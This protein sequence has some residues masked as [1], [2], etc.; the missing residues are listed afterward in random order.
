MTSA[1]RE[2][3][4]RRAAAGEEAARLALADALD[5]E[6]RHDDAIN[7]LAAAARA[8]S[9]AAMGRVG[10]RILI[11]DRAP[12]LPQQ[13]VGLVRDAA[14]AGD[15]EALTLLATLTAAGAHVQQSWSG[16][17]DLIQR[18]AERGSASARGQL[19]V[20]ASDRSLAAEAKASA[21]AAPP[22]VWGRLRA[23]VD[24][25]GFSR[26]SPGITLCE[27]PL[28]RSFP[29]FAAPEVCDWLVARAATRLKRAEVYVGDPTKVKVGE[30]RT[31]SIGAFWLTEIDLVQLALQARMAS[32]TGLSYRHMESPSVLHYAVGQQFHDHYD[33]IDPQTPDYQ[34]LIARHG[35]RVV[36]FLV[37]LNDG[38]EGGETAFPRLDIAHTG[39]RG[40]GLY[41]A[42]A[43]PSGGPDVRALHAG[44]PPTR[45]EKWIVSQ[46]IRSR[47]FI[48]GAA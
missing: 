20:L 34:A 39:A 35:E 1:T 14:S 33:F 32:A 11:G 37:Y 15:P 44:R 23:A 2:D 7:M 41:F 10:A 47:P 28:I 43:L 45:G 48:P 29:D 8:G 36:T 38:Y 22:E 26:T 27:G 25:A 13:G 42:N 12:S 19:A 5:S 3:L 40:E 24:V 16:A 21:D 18:A 9:A 31:N 30:S 17:L 6:G 46:F 4:E